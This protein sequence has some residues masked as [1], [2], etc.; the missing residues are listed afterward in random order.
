VA[1]CTGATSAAIDVSVMSL[2][3]VASLQPCHACLE[4]R[5]GAINHP[6]GWSIAAACDGDGSRKQLQMCAVW[7]ARPAMKSAFRGPRTEVPARDL[8]RRR[9]DAGG[10]RAQL[11]PLPMA[12]SQEETPNPERPATAGGRDR[13]ADAGR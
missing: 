7:K 8:R 10:L 4:E 5:R 13:S 11:G 6:D 1:G 9:L 12:R 3:C 2:S